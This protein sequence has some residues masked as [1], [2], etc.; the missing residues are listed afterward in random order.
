MK[1]Q[2]K[3]VINKLAAAVLSYSI[4]LIP[5][6][7][8]I[9]QDE[10]PE[11][12]VTETKRPRKAIE[13]HQPSDQARE[14][15]SQELRDFNNDGYADLAVGV[16]NDVTGD[17]DFS[18][19]AVNVFYGGPDGFEMGCCAGRPGPQILTQD[20]P[21]VQG[22]GSES[23]DFGTA[24]ASCDYNGD[25]FTDL[26][27]GM[28]G[29]Q[30]TGGTHG[31]AVN[32]IYGSF[33]GLTTT[34][35]S[36][37]PAPQF[38]SQDSSG[39]PGVAENGDRFGE[40]LACG[41]FDNDGL[42]DL[43]IGVPS[44]DIGSISGAGMV[45][46]LYGTST[47]GL[48]ASGDQEWNQDT[49]GIPDQVEQSDRFGDA[50]AAGDF[51]GN[52]CDDLVIGSPHETLSVSGTNFSWAGAVTVIYGDATE[53]LTSTKS[54]FPAA[55]L[56]TQNSSFVPDAVEQGDEFGM[57]LT[58][59][60]FNGGNTD[61]AI[62]SREGVFIIHGR[63]GGL[64]ATSGVVIGGNQ[65]V[66]AQQWTAGSLGFSAYE[67]GFYFDL[68]LASGDFDGD[69]FHDLAM[70]S[71]AVT[72]SPSL[73]SAGAVFVVYGS[74]Y[75][76]TTS[77]KAPQ[78]WTEDSTDIAGTAA[79]NDR[80]GWAVAAGGYGSGN[81]LQDDLVIGVPDQ[82]VGS[83]TTAGAINVIYGS[84]TGLNAANNRVI[85]QNNTNVPGTAA[86]FDRFG[87]ALH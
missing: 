10:V 31:G 71:Q 14:V 25:G 9:A 17:R 46:V 41:D 45:H 82:Q 68:A 4:I 37:I 47:N 18:A 66:T 11:P 24:L 43:A 87:R 20:S 56:W 42:G 61:L 49:L 64:S 44:E 15:G 85:H 67:P 77:F 53:G 84:T 75:G 6:S 13:N 78:M 2:D 59:G 28:P 34:A 55:Q 36:N 30:V 38:W 74:T 58:T 39:I 40:T 21:N 63:N 86:Q 83:A 8:V 76:L 60:N 7:S 23:D 5:F 33:A 69:G 65:N 52:G 3:N 51:D 27:I 16:P 26:A 73:S 32:V 70:G 72:L 29:R 1:K 12:D 57:S 80:F 50:L 19:G 79:Q 35:G 62:G 22:S 54:N 81:G 48:T